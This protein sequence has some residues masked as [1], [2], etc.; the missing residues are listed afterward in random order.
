MLRGRSAAS[1]PVSPRQCRQGRSTARRQVERRRRLRILAQHS[2]SPS[3]VS[4]NRTYARPLWLSM[5]TAG[6]GQRRRRPP[7][8]RYHRSSH[9]AG[10]PIWPTTRI[11][12]EYG[13]ALPSGMTGGSKTPNPC[14]LRGAD[15]RGANLSGANLVARRTSAGRTSARR[16]SAGRT[17]AGRTSSGRTSA[18]RTSARANLAG[19][20]PLRASLPA[21]FGA[22]LS[23]ANLYAANLSGAD[24]S[25]A[26]LSG[27]NL[28]R[29]N[30]YACY[31][32]QDE[33][34]G[35]GS[36]GLPCLRDFR[37]G[38]EAGGSKT[39]RP[40]DHHGRSARDHRR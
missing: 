14:D 38:P 3:P 5:G 26:D 8:L 22:N 27:A 29:A 6:R 21:T 12:P 24:L 15:L 13:R 18:G 36:H 35:R 17:S 7:P 37:M 11:S 20:E 23:G 30:L 1:N 39:T 40:R 2:P 25:D 28:V 34:D 32:G 19:G 31:L 9:A 16:T 4:H 10:A 33:P